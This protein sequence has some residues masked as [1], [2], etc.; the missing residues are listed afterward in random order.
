MSDHH[1]HKRQ[2]CGD[3]SLPNMSKNIESNH[4][5]RIINSSPLFANEDSESTSDRLPKGMAMSN[6]SVSFVSLQVRRYNVEIGNH[7]SCRNGT[8]IELGWT[9]TQDPTQCLE[10]YETSRQENFP[11]RNRKE[12]LLPSGQRKV[13]LKEAGHSEKEIKQAEVMKVPRRLEHDIASV[14]RT[15]SDLSCCVPSASDLIDTQERLHIPTSAMKN[16]TWDTVDCLSS[17]SMPR[18]FQAEQRALAVNPLFKYFEL[19]R[20]VLR[21]NNKNI[22]SNNS[23]SI[24]ILPRSSYGSISSSSSYYGGRSSDSFS[25]NNSLKDIADRTYNTIALRPNASASAQDLKVH[26]NVHLKSR[27]PSNSG[28]RRVFMPR[29][30]LN[31]DRH[32]RINL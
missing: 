28:Y 16:E 27:T 32:S 26:N 1:E 2:R 3:V 22:I 23:R 14:S 7:P 17:A 4:S 12:L 15:L 18:N 30:P 20:P 24:T 11:R 8:P 5:I 21:G 6:R 9:Y 29:K 25:R 31:R 13:I 10:S 19:K